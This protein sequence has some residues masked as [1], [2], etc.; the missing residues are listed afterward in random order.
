MIFK[1]IVVDRK[2]NSS[3]VDLI[4]SSKVI[5]ENLPKKIGYGYRI[6]LLARD[7]S[8]INDIVDEKGYVYKKGEL[9]NVV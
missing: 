7:I 8:Y 2:N 5:Q 4:Y 6:F 3:V 1:K 9:L